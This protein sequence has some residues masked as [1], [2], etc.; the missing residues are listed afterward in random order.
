MHLIFCADPDPGSVLL[1]IQTHEYLLISFSAN[2]YAKI[3]H[4][5]FY[6]DFAGLSFLE[7][8]FP[9]PSENY[10]FPHKLIMISGKMYQI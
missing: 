10:F 6:Q 4:P 2:L 7:K 5:Q 8:S 3:V 9:P 1:K